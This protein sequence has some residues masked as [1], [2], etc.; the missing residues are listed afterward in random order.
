MVQ[1]ILQKL[2]FLTEYYLISCFFNKIKNKSFQKYPL[3]KFIKHAPSI[4]S[5]EATCLVTL[6]SPDEIKASLWSLKPFKAPGP[7]G[8]HPGFFQ[9]CW[10]IVGDSVIKE[11]SNIFNSGKVPK[12]LNKTLISL[13]PKCMGL[14]LLANLGVLVCIIWCTRLSLKLL[15]L[16]FNPYLATSSPLIKLH[17]SR[18]DMALIM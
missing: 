10:H 5:F 4:S 3:S 8:L 14:K 11:V 16:V 15:W 7:D 13:I 12:Y 9:R 18:V 1:I 17:S 2:N 6:P